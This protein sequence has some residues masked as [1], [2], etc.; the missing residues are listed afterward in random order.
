MNAGKRINRQLTRERQ[1]RHIRALAPVSERMALELARLH[2]G[3][4][5]NG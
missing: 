4:N 1:M 5:T 3:M 2:F